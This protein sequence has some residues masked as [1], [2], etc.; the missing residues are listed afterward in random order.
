MFVYPMNKQ[1]VKT[2]LIP[3]DFTIASLYTLRQVLE[4]YETAQ[5]KI[6][7]MYADRLNDSISDLLFDSSYKKVL[8]LTSPEFQEALYILKNRFETIIHSIRIELFHGNNVNAFKNFIGGNHIDMIYIPKGY[9]LK[10][11]ANGFNPIP[12][13]KKSR[14]PLQ[15]IEWISRSNNTDP[16][17][18]NSL[19]K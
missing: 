15:E 16:D 1:S 12:L 10:L 11:K 14:I 7:L 5:V 3:I 6:V 4:H 2:I 18:L 8:S 19:F 17:Q 9:D 13:I